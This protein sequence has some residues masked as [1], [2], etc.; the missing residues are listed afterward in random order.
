[1]R[2]VIVSATTLLIT[3]APLVGAHTQEDEM[4]PQFP[5]K[6]NAGDL[7]RTCASS[8]LTATGRVRSRYC[9]GFVSGV[10]EAVRLLQKDGKIERK[11]CTPPDITAAALADAYVKYGVSHKGELPDTAVE[12]VLHALA[13]AYPCAARP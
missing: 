5:Q 9:A 7:L 12:V 10:E 2:L 6:Q 4:E 3:L 13:D 1:M 8:R 11:V